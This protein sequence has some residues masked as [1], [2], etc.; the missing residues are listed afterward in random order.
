MLGY[1]T[2]GAH[3]GV[4][5]TGGLRIFLFLGTSRGKRRRPRQNG[6]KGRK[7]RPGSLAERVCQRILPRDS[8]VSRLQF[9]ERLFSQ[10]RAVWVWEF[11]ERQ[12]AMYSKEYVPIP[13]LSAENAGALAGPLQSRIVMGPPRT[14]GI[15]VVA[16]RGTRNDTKGSVHQLP[17]CGVQRIII[18]K[19]KQMRD[20]RQALLAGQQ[21]GTSQAGGSALANSRRGVVGQEVEQRSNRAVVTKHRQSFHRPIARVFAGVVYVVQQAVQHFLRFNAAIS[22]RTEPPQRHPA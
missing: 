14:P 13:R 22:Q 17:R 2:I 18:S 15:G 12:N 8:R 4:I 19:I 20:G 9:L 7:N 11:I 1:G 6:D 5:H 16:E 10:F 21:T 3:L